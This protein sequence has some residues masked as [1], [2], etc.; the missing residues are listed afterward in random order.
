MQKAMSALLPKADIAATS[1]TTKTLE[2]FNVSPEGFSVTV[3]QL[4]RRL[5]SAS[6]VSRADPMRLSRWRSV[7]IPRAAA[8]RRPTRIVKLIDHAKSTDAAHGRSTLLKG[9]EAAIVCR[10]P[11]PTRIL[12]T[13]SSIIAGQAIFSLVVTNILHRRKNTV[14]RRCRSLKKTRLPTLSM[15]ASSLGLPRTVE[16]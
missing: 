7:T 3:P 6:C 12:G 15:Q 14:P 13:P 11:T 16:P 10:R 1:A 8:A 5:A 2:R 9:E 4:I